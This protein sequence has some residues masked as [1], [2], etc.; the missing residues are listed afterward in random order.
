MYLQS[1]DLQD[2]RAMNGFFPKKKKFLTPV[3]TRIYMSN[4]LV[5]IYTSG[6][7]C[8]QKFK[9]EYLC[10]VSYPYAFVCAFMWVCMRA[11]LFCM[12]ACVHVCMYIWYICMQTCTHV[13]VCD[14]VHMY[15]VYM[16]TCVCA[17][18]Y[19]VCECLYAYIY[20]YTFSHGIIFVF[21]LLL[22]VCRKFL[23][24]SLLEFY[25][26]DCVANRSLRIS[27]CTV[28]SSKY[29]TLGCSDA[30]H[31]NYNT[32]TPCNTLW[33]TATQRENQQMQQIR[34]QH[35]NTLSV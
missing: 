3:L 24:V 34:L 33:R 27:M 5:Y 16:C 22:N 18:L 1:H 29:S 11:Y 20:I 6:R 32:A 13:F 30:T 17:Y 10:T 14:C 12:C 19:C 8:I 25:I 26:V 2:H 28:Q 35:C 9:A 21:F 15:I 7:S 23:K 4:W 31:Y